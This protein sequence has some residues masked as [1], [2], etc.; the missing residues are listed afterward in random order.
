[1]QLKPA[2]EAARCFA[3]CL[4]NCQGDRAAL[5]YLER[6]QQSIDGNSMLKRE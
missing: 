4:D 6:C 3:E 1:M 5:S 2:S